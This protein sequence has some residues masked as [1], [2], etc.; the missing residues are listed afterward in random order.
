MSNT[1]DCSMQS[2]TACFEPEAV[3]AEPPPANE[4]GSPTRPADPSR[5]A[6]I[7]DCVSSL[8]VAQLVAGVA[9]GL[10]CF[11]ASAACPA[12]IGA[13]AGALIGW[14]EGQC[15]EPAVDGKR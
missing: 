13:S 1:I 7:D 9:T 2:H 5:Y 15:E 4:G 12:L 11:V 10:G 6:C 8:G 14:C 3:A